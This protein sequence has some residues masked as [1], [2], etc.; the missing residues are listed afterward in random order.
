MLTHNKIVLFII[1]LIDIS[2]FIFF[3]LHNDFNNS[4]YAISVFS[5]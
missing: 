2:M 4:C 5:P 1:V 3:Q